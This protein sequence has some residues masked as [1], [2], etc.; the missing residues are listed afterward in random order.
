M[1][2]VSHAPVVTMALTGTRRI[3]EL[4][5]RILVDSGSRN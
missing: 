1:S 2:A 5:A 3:A 4:D